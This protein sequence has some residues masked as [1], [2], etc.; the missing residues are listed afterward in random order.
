VTKDY[1]EE[2]SALDFPREAVLSHWADFVA[3]TTYRGNVL[4]YKIPDPPTPIVEN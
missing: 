2:C 1:T 4:I 3:I